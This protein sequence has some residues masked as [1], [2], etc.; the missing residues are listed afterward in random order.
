MRKVTAAEQ[1]HAQ[2]RTL[3]MWEKVRENAYAAGRADVVMSAEVAIRGIKATI[4]TLKFLQRPDIE[5]R[6]RVS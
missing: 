3:E 4:E 2:E 5:V 6:R 1:Q